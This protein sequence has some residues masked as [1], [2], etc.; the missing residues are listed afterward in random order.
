[1]TTTSRIPLYDANGGK[2]GRISPLALAALIDSGLLDDERPAIETST[3]T[4][5]HCIECKHP[6]TIGIF[7]SCCFARLREHEAGWAAAWYGPS[8]REA[9]EIAARAEVQG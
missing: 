4:N 5:A 7:C 2:I 3:I 9:M 6:R 1:M 8:W